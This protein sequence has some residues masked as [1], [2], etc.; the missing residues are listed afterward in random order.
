MDSGNARIEADRIRV[1][2]E[3]DFVSPGGQFQT[4]LGG[5]DAASAL[6]RITGDPDIHLASVA[7]SGRTPTNW[8]LALRPGARILLRCPFAIR[9][10][11]FAAVPCSF[12]TSTGGARSRTPD[13]RAFH[14]PVAS[15][16][17]GPVGARG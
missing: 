15:S 17:C 5:D 16:F 13:P 8:P 6:G 1:A 11:R 4:Q 2:D 14:T 7:L 3:V 9:A 12:R 10:R